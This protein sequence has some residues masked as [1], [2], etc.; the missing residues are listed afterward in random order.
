[1][2]VGDYVFDWEIGQWGL[3]LDQLPCDSYVLLYEDGEQGEAFENALGIPRE[4]PW[5][6]RT[7]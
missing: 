3:I 1:M 6:K 5:M 7:S 2:Q 4:S